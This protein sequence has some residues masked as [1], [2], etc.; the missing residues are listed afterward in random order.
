MSEISYFKRILKDEFFEKIE[1]FNQFLCSEDISDIISAAH[2]QWRDR[3]WT[4]MQTL[5]AFLIQVLNVGCSCRQAV[6]HTLAGQAVSGKQAIASPDPS[7]YCQGRTRLPLSLFKSAVQLVGQRVEETVTSAYVWCGRRVWIVDGSSCSMPDTPE[8]RATFGQPDNIKTG[9]GFPVAKIVTMFSWATG[10][11]Q[12]V[13]IGVYRSS[14]LILWRQLWGQLQSGDIV[15]GDRLYCAYSYI[16]ELLQIH[17]DGAFRLHGG[18]ART[19]SFRQ[20]ERLGKDDR[21]QVWT[22][23]IQCPKGISQACWQSLP[24]TLTVRVIR[25]ATQ[26]PGFR[27][28]TIMVAT[29]L[30]DPKAY[31]LEHIA[32]LYRDRWTAELRLRDVKTTLHMDVLRCK[33]PQMV[34]KEIY[35]HF[36]AYNLIRVL[37]LRA[38]R[39]HHRPLHRLSFAGTVQRLEVICP[40]LLLFSGPQHITILCKLL[41]TWIAHDVL[42]NRPNRVEPR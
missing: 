41:L 40:Y 36:L 17:C 1:L 7:A 14:E 42:P 28:N 25:F 2:Y 23:P 30:L 15:L 16:S 3:I 34:K 5:W 32:A 12:D 8:L 27:S 39:T 21:L 22:R 26:V 33:S 35:M 31:P 37:M 4:P 6:A 18:R 10:A 11:V 20:G 24:T 38:S 9:C 19:L 29:T 13:A